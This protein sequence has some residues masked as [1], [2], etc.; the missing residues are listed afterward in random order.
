LAEKRRL[1]PALCLFCSLLLRINSSNHHRR[2]LT[3]CSAQKVGWAALPGN[4]KGIKRLPP[5]P[6]SPGYLYTVS[7]F[8]IKSA[9]CRER[10]PRSAR[11]PRSLILTLTRPS[12]PVFSWHS[13]G[14]S[15]EALLFLTLFPIVSSKLLQWTVFMKL[16]F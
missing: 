13:R 3:L 4:C 14:T 10:P 11:L 6:P 8:T 9:F 12:E 5:R 2:C 15:Y 16:S 7:A 1:C